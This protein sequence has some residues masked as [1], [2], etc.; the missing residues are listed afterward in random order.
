HK[1]VEQAKKDLY[2]KTLFG[3]RR[4]IPE[5]ASQKHMERAFGERVA[6]NSPIQGTAADVIKI[7]MIHVA[8]RLEEEKL[9]AHLILQ[10]HDELIIECREKDVEQVK[11][12]LTSEMEKA[13]SLSVKLTAEA[14]IG[15]TWFDA[16]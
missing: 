11:T 15:K 6:M 8:R 2:V 16:K 5:L 3:R 9:D 7:A 4:S 14:G 10:V 1:A 13:V 12:L